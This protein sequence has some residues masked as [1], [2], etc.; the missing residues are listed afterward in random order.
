MAAHAAIHD[1]PHENKG[2][3]TGFAGMTVEALAAQERQAREA[4]QARVTAERRARRLTLG[5]AATVL[6]HAWLV[7]LVGAV[8]GMLFGLPSLQIKGLYL[9]VATLA[10][11][12]FVDWVFARVKWFTNYS[13]SGGVST[14]PVEMFGW[15]IDTPVEKYL[16]ILGIA[17]LWLYERRRLRHPGP[18]AEEFLGK[19]HEVAEMVGAPVKVA[20]EKFAAA[21]GRRLLDYCARVHGPLMREHSIGH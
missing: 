16:F 20:F 8:I 19:S 6:A 15:V 21:D 10:A 13:S 1:F 7:P 11:Q 17:G 2:V 12:F 18:V 3:D 4:A 5:L 9:G 14:A